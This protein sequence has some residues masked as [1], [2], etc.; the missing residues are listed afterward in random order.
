MQQGSVDQKIMGLMSKAVDKL[1]DPLPKWAK[2]LLVALLVVGSIYAIARDGFWHSLLH[3]I[4]S[5][6]I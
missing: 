3:V 6:E 1:V 5:P 2:F 4:F